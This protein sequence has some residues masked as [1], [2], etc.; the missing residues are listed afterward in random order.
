M[1]LILSPPFSPNQGL[2]TFVSEEQRTKCDLNHAHLTCLSSSSFPSQENLSGFAEVAPW[3]TLHS[4]RCTVTCAGISFFSGFGWQLSYILIEACPGFQNHFTQHSRNGR[5]LSP[6]SW[7]S[8][9]HSGR[10]V[11]VSSPCPFLLHGVI[12]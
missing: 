4:H 1:S 3:L 7:R 9:Q 10:Q 11:P 8:P 12:Y 6:E 5:S 2:A